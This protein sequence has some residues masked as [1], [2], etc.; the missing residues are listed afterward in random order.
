MD[1]VRA[2]SV[3]V[4]GRG[5]CVILAGRNRRSEQ[6]DGRGWGEGEGTG[7]EGGGW[8]SRRGND[9]ADRFLSSRGVKTMYLIV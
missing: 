8:R 7:G 4:R 6:G 5:G 3:L 9:K 2:G 1:D